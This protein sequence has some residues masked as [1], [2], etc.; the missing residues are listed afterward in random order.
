MQGILGEN[1]DVLDRLAQLLLEK[2]I[3]QGEELRKM[4]GKPVAEIPPPPQPCTPA[5]PIRS[6]LTFVSG[7]YQIYSAG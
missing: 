4:L 1:R 2:E 6:G 5:S 7:L 3:V